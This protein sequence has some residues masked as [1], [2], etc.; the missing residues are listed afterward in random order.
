M[1]V[2]S[3]VK[4][5]R[6]ASHGKQREGIHHVLK[7]FQRFLIAAHEAARE[8]RYQ[9]MALATAPASQMNLRL[10]KKVRVE[11]VRAACSTISQMKISLDSY[12]GCGESK[13]R[14]GRHV[15]NAGVHF[16]RRG[17]VEKGDNNPR[18]NDQPDQNDACHGARVC[19][20]TAS[21]RRFV[22]GSS[23]SIFAKATSTMRKL[24]PKKMN[25]A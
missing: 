20:S 7:A 3:P 24:R 5:S 16:F 21:R 1:R 23:F 18:W 10:P 12:A 8:E 13:H 15:F 17:H 19:Q 22:R 9:P 6:S 11:I 25:R 4:K 14:M 2:I